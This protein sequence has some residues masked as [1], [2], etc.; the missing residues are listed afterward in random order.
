MTYRVRHE[1]LQNV[2]VQ[3]VGIIP[4]HVIYFAKLVSGSACWF[5]RCTLA[6]TNSQLMVIPLVWNSKKKSVS[7]YEIWPVV[8]QMRHDVQFLSLWG[9]VNWHRGER[10]NR[11]QWMGNVQIN[12]PC[13]V[14]D[15]SASWPFPDAERK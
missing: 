3:A 6:R 10:Q 4:L 9:H 12:A 7:A 15:S 13:N 2:Y 8:Q 14:I 5:L 1:A 11:T